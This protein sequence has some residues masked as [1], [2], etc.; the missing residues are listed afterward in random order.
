MPEQPTCGLI[1][2]AAGA[3]TRMGRP[4]QLLPAGGKPLLRHVAEVGLSG[5]VSPVVVVLGAHAAEIAPCLDGLAVQ[6]VVN[7]RWTEGMGASLRAGM[8]AMKRAAPAAQAVIVALADQPDFSPDHLERMVEIHRVSGRAIVASEADGTLRPPVLF[9]SAWFSRLLT[10]EGDAGART[11]LQENRTEVA[12]VP[13]AMPADLD[14][15]ADY[16]KF[17][18]RTRACQPKGARETPE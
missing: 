15:P 3:S 10:L 12:I 7:D 1:L 6:V 2:L 18:R 14:T 9:A 8:Q 11:L 16:E 13:L 4:K 5:P 17:L